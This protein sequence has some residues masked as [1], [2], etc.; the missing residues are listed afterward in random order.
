MESTVSDHSRAPLL[1]RSQANWSLLT[2]QIYVMAMSNLVAGKMDRTCRDGG[3]NAHRGVVKHTFKQQR[4][5]ELS[6]GK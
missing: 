2:L 3:R 4:D 5:T 6:A 1:E